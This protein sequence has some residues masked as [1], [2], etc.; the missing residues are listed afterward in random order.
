MRTKLV[1]IL[2]ED[3]TFIIMSGIRQIST[4]PGLVSLFSKRGLWHSFTG[5]KSIH[6]FPEG[7]RP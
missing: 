3:G 1:Q 4:Q 6:V 5:V 2:F 7:R